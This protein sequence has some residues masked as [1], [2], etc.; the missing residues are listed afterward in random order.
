MRKEQV[1]TR[2]LRDLAHLVAD[3]AAVNAQFA[4]KLDLIILDLGRSKRVV[5]KRVQDDQVPDIFTAAADKSDPEFELWLAGLELPVLKAIV[6]KHDLD[7]ST[8]TRKWREPAKFAKF[9]VDQLRARL[10]RGSTFL[11]GGIGTG[12]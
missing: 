7:T 5:T 9:I 12:S 8:R 6:R 3:E 4:A 2:I 10:R 1:L 11:T